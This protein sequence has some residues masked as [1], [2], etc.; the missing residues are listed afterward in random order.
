MAQSRDIGN[1]I[2]DPSD[3]R[4]VNHLFLIG[5]D[6]YQH[7]SKLRNAVS[8]AQAIKDLL[9]KEYEF[10]EANVRELYNS[11]AT[12]KNVIRQLK[13]YESLTAKDNLI[14]YYSGHGYYRRQMGYLVPVDGEEEEDFIPNTSIRDRLKLISAQHIVTIFDSCFSG[15]FIATKDVVTERLSGK[16]SRWMLAAGDIELVSDGIASH[17]S[18]FTGALLE[19]LEKSD[20][21]ELRIDDLFKKAQSRTIANGAEQTPIGGPLPISGHENGVFYFIRRNTEAETWAK[22][23]LK[24]LSAVRAFIRQFP[25]SKSERMQQARTLEGELQAATDREQAATRERDAYERAKK[26]DL[27]DMN[28]FLREYPRSDFYDDIKNLRNTTEEEADWKQAKRHDTFDAYEKFLDKY[29]SGNFSDNARQRI[30]EKEKGISEDAAAK[31]WKK[32]QQ[33]DTISAYRG[34]IALYPNSVHHSAATVRLKALEYQQQHTDDWVKAQQTNTIAGYEAFLRNHSTSSHRRAAENNIKVLQPKPPKPKPAPIPAEPASEVPDNKT[35]K[36]MFI[37][38]G[39]L[40]LL[41][42]AIK[43]IPWGGTEVPEGTALDGSTQPDTTT[44]PIAPASEDTAKNMTMTAD[45]NKPGNKNTGKKPITQPAEEK[46]TAATPSITYSPYTPNKR[47]IS[48]LG[49]TLVEIRGGSFKMGSTENSDEKPIHTVSMRDYYIG[50]TEVT[51]A[52]FVR[53]L[54]DIAGNVSVASDGDA[55]NYNG[56]KICELKNSSYN[57]KFERILYA[58]SSFSVKSGYEKHPVVMV[59]WYGA[60]E[61][62]KWVSRTYG[63]NYRLPTEAEWEYA[64]RGGQNTQGYKYP[65]SNSV[66]SVAWYDGNSGSDT[67]PVAGRSAN[68]AGL[69]DMSG[70]V[71]EW[72][73]DV[74]HDSYKGAPADGSAWTSG[75]NQNVRVLRGGSWYYL[76]YY[77][78]VAVRYY[79]YPSI[80]LYLI[81]FRLVQD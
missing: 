43:L 36:M 74:Y 21:R 30:E 55:V 5:I 23:D 41:L 4:L 3:R 19:I 51:N 32:A 72:C 31:D 65:G 75:G 28:R 57:G 37:G 35:K 15:S 7:H 26:G 81:G 12:Y 56:N 58:G 54:N 40:L 46:K 61:F 53:F 77:C 10:E 13:A 47:S 73:R 59:T 33:S 45:P 80:A 18:P 48:A 1:G 11:A 64:A 25:D 22:T 29:P 42:L 2:N 8:D 6:D 24:S 62:C 52:Q 20:N 17:N 34:F 76:D 38:G 68:E 63:G 69:Y 44:L 9:V 60:T 78:R 49:M 71:W 79:N 39:G 50:Q 67:H 27:S 16:P 70:N 66:G 14:V